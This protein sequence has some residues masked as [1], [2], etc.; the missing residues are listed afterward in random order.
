[1]MDTQS[2]AYRFISTIPKVPDMLLD[3]LARSAQG[4]HRGADMPDGTLICPWCS[5]RRKPVIWPCP[6][7]IEIAKLRAHWA[8]DRP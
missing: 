5:T 6:K 7:Q 4:M 8:S 1:M 3:A 2:F